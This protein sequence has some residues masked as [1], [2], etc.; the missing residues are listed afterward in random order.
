MLLALL[1]CLGAAFPQRLQAQTE[2]A[3]LQ[4]SDKEA[5]AFFG[6]SVAIS[7]DRAIVGARLGASDGLAAG[8]AYFFERDGSGTW[9]EVAKV[10]ASDKETGD[11]F[12]VSVA[13]SGDRAIVGA[14][15]EDTGGSDAGAAYF[16]ERDAVSGT[17][18]EV[19]K[20]QASDKHAWMFMAASPIIHCTPS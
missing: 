13:I 5:G 7:G 17:W 2:V 14:P 4:A 1:I 20:V 9:I 3:K 15:A 12:G 11:F 16:F 10:Q 18:S 19:A 6:G 8:A